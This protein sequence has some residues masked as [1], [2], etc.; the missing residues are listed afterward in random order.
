[1][2]KIGIYKITNP[3]KKVYIGQSTNIN[4]RINQYRKNCDKSQRLLFNSI[5]K[6]GFENHTVEIL[7]ECSVEQ[8]NDLE[9][10]FISQ[11]DS[12]DRKIGMNLTTGG[13]DYFFHTKE[14]RKRMSAAQKGNTKTLGRKQTI[15]EIAKRTR[16]T[17]GQKRSKDQREKMSKAQKGKNLSNE[18][19]MKMSK[20]FQYRGAKKVID[21]STGII[22]GRVLDAANA[23]N[24]KRGTLTSKLNGQITN[25]TT[26]KYV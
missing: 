3:S 9:R 21:T 5:K 12:T 8:L 20:S 1:M 18:T 17:K 4:R 26:M 11:Y 10:K 24:I 23:I 19:K 22:Y 14:T 25:N 6:Y 13:Q 7:C 2:K 15:E 16:K